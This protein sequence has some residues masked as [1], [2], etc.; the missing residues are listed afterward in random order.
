MALAKDR[1]YKGQLIRECERVEGEHSG[2]WIIQTYQLLTG[3]A[4]DDETCP[5][6]NTLHEAKTYIA[7]SLTG[8]HGKFS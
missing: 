8:I 2:R 6:F 1:K 7:H 4:W 5:H 3:M